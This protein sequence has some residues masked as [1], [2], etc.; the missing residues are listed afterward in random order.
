MKKQNII[1][2][3]IAI[4]LSQVFAIYAD[5]KHIIKEVTVYKDRALILREQKIITKLGENVIAFEGLTNKLDPK[6]LRAKVNDKDIELLGINWEKIIVNKI[7]N[8][9]LNALELERISLENDIKKIQ[10][11]KSVLDTNLKFI[12]EYRAFSRKIIS[13]QAI[14]EQSEDDVK[15]WGY[16]LHFLKTNQQ[17]IL[18]KTHN[19][20]I[21]I[22]E[23]KVKLSATKANLRKY[24]NPESRATITAFVTIR[25]KKQIEGQINI[26]YITYG[27]G[28]S[29]KYDARIDV[30]SKKLDLTYYAT[31]IQKS[32][33]VWNDVQLYLSTAQPQIDAKPP[34]L[35]PLLL[36]GNYIVKKNKREFKMVKEKSAKTD[37][38]NVGNLIEPIEE[39]NPL[40]SIQDKGTS[41][42]FKIKDLANIYPDGRPYQVTV[43]ENIC[44]T[45][46]SFE[47][48]PVERPYIYLK[49]AA[50][51]KSQYPLL[52]GAVAIFRGG[53]YIGTSNI[54]YTPPNSP[55][56]L[57]A[58]IDE[59]ISIK[60]L[61]KDGYYNK[62]SLLG[63]TKTD[64][65][66]WTFIIKNNT[67]NEKKLRLLEGIPVSQLEEVC[68]KIITETTPGYEFNK[69]KG[70]LVWNITLKPNEQK[71]I[72][73][74]YTITKDN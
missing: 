64:M 17:S 24:M 10:D 74:K 39:E 12:K 38:K 46:L 20:N 18:E 31:V 63:G 41:V 34:K 50:F 54:I 51:N 53:G 16:S 57:F 45:T 72:F 59:N 13:E 37:D 47:T 22:D 69:K 73:L 62:K 42:T 15:K 19:L 7:Q 5:S 48:I 33:E 28:W 61:K 26:S 36:N 11:E 40:N 3:S 52:P 8:S 29:P 27:A 4:I 21:L 14:K 49:V 9:K 58:G 65:F 67:K 30:N 71:K 56:N 32:G 6:S 43:N 25:A 70:I 60:R 55:I 66:L 23:I 1:K 35:H 44:D 2:I 68:V